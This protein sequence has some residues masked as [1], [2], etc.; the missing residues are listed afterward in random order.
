V[1]KPIFLFW[2]IILA[3]AMV[4]ALVP[5]MAQSV[6][7]VPAT[8]EQAA[9]QQEAAELQVDEAAEQLAQAPEEQEQQTPEEQEQQAPEEQ[10]QQAPEEQEQQAPEEQE[11]QTPEEQQAVECQIDIKPGS[12]PNSIN[13][14]SNGV[15]PVAILTTADFDAATVDPA[16]VAFGPDGAAPVHY[17][18]EDV[19]GDGDIDMIL[20]FKTQDTGIS[21]GDTEATLTAETEGGTIISCSDSVRTV[22]PQG[23]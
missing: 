23:E 19:D 2:G 21:P 18:L 1:K 16:T 7:L 3:V 12:F 13:P 5:A 4:F 6:P 15:I 9:E 17:A 14:N 11:Q 22:P 8:Q 10:E 20:H